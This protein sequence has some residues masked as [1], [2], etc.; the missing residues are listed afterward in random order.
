[1]GPQTDIHSGNLP[2]NSTDSLPLLQTLDHLLLCC[3]PLQRFA[4][5]VDLASHRLSD[6]QN[7]QVTSQEQP[8]QPNVEV[9]IPPHINI[10]K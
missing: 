10:P 1:M 5:V 2:W 9:K 3:F 6:K 4:E 7:R 8:T